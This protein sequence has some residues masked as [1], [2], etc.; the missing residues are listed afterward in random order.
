MAAVSDDAKS[1]IR[2][3]RRCPECAVR[4]LVSTVGTYRVDC[5]SCGWG[6]ELDRA[7]PKPEKSYAEMR[8]GYHPVVYY[9][10]FGER[11][12]IG[13]TTDLEKRLSALPYDEL[14]ATEPGH[15]DVERER[16]QQFRRSR[17]Y[18]NREWFH[19]TDEVQAH[20]ASL[21]G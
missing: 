11:V 9:V 7:A 21:R 17:I 1:L 4:A 10:R 8:P 16:H 3:D 15:Y 20:I 14:L 18:A 6:E 5:A 19:L 2:W 13:T 12:K